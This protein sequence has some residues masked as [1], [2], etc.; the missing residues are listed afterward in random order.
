[1]KLLS[2][3][4][5]SSSYFLR[6]AS[7]NT[8]DRSRSPFSR[9]ISGTVWISFQRGA[10]RRALRNVARQRFTVAM[11]HVRPSFPFAVTGERPHREPLHEPFGRLSTGGFYEGQVSAVTEKVSRVS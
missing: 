9:E 7:V 8:N 3:S 6:S 10:M 1:M 5:A 11:L 4:G 2:G